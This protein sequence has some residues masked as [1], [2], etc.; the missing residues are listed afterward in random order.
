MI[1]AL[2]L[3]AFLCLFTRTLLMINDRAPLHQRCA[4]SSIYKMLALC[5]RDLRLMNIYT[6]KVISAVACRVG[7]ISSTHET[8]TFGRG[9]AAFLVPWHTLTPQML[10]TQ[11]PMIP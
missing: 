6:I 1:E 10:E 2:A 8:H 7:T 11:P 9:G 4:T 5:S 3:P